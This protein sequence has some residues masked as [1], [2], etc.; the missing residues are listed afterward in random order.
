MLAADERPVKRTTVQIWAG[1]RIVATIKSQE[2]NERKD[3]KECDADSRRRGKRQD[4]P[5]QQGW[6]GEMRRR[7]SQSGEYDD[8]HRMGEGTR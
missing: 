8:K 2:R 1:I 6:Q 4:E 5:F 7:G 3:G